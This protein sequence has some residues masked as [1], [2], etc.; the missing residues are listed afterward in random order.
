MEI[1]KAVVAVY[2]DHDKA[3]QAIAYLKK[4]DIDLS[5]VSL[6]GKAEIVEDHLKVVSVKKIKSA[7]VSIGAIMG[8]TLGVLAGASVITVPGLGFIFG[9]GAF[10]GALSGLTAGLFGG[11]LASFL[12]SIGMR[13]DKLT[14]YKT[15]LQE[16]KFIVI[17][18]NASEEEVEKAR[19]LLKTEGQHL[20]EIE[21]L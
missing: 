15:H 12:L 21:E 18:H 8:T 2:D 11:E 13:K 4:H 7:P 10:V 3:H 14:L 16:G 6:L 9:A 20:D 17:F 5:K 1:K 19:Q